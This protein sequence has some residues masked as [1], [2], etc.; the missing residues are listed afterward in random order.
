VSLKF[1]AG[2]QGELG[3]V[4]VMRF[5]QAADGEDLLLPFGDQHDFAIV[6]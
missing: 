3:F 2:Q 5:G 1:V 4:S 6:A